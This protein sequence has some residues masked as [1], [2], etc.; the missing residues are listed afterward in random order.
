[1]LLLQFWASNTVFFNLDLSPFTVRLPCQRTR[2]RNRLAHDGHTL[3][4]QSRS[5]ARTP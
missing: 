5:T 3:C 2:A 4:I 1:M